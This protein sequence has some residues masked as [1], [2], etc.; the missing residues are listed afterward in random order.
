MNLERCSSFRV[1]SVEGFLDG[2]NH[3][4]KGAEVRKATDCVGNNHT[5]RC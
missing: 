2:R 3:H 1:D 4:S 5:A